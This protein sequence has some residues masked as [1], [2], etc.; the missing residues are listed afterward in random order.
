MKMV[1]DAKRKKI[2][3][4]PLLPLIGFTLAV[5]LGVIAYFSAPLLVDFAK[6]NL[7]EQEFEQRLAQDNIEEGQVQIAFA[8]V[9]WLAL[10]GLT[11]TIVAAAIGEDPEKENAIVRPR[12]D[13]SPKEWKKYREEWAKVEK[14]RLARA[15]QVKREQKKREKKR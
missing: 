10:F 7:G 2:T 3:A 4:G 14:K 12:E 5:T 1:K 15:E 11:M 8:V 13:A 6:T 9:L